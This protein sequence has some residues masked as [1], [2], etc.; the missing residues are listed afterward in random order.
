MGPALLAAGV[1]SRRGNETD[2]VASLRSPPPN[3]GG[4]DDWEN[5]MVRCRIALAG[6]N[7][8]ARITNAVAEDGLLTG[9]EASLLNLQGTELEILSACE[10]RAGEVKIGKGVARGAT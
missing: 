4:Y 3:L 5:P 8:A 6:A 9:L 7:H 1:R 10:S 2:L